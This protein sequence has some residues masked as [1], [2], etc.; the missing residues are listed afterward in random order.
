MIVVFARR[1]SPAAGTAGCFMASH[2][3]RYYCGKTGH[4]YFFNKGKAEEA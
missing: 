4:T 2:Y 3:D 1:Y